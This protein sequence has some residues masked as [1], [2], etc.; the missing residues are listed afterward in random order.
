MSDD[1]DES[2]ELVVRPAAEDTGKGKSLFARAEE[3]LLATNGDFMSDK[4]LN[5]PKRIGLIIAFLVFGVFGVWAAVAPLDGAIHAPG[6]VVLE[7]YRKPI[8]HFEGGIVKSVLVRDGSIVAKGEPIII[9]DNTQSLANLDILQGQ[10]LALLALEARLASERDSLDNIV[11]P[12]ALVAAS[13]PV[14]QIEMNAQ[15]QIF[16][17]RKTYLD[18]ET[19]VLTQ[20]ITQL[21]SRIEGLKAS[22]ASKETLLDSFDAEIKDAT[23]LL[24]EG[25]VEKTRMRE[26]ERTHV[27]TAGDIAEQTATIASTEV[28]V[29]ETKLQILQL[30]NQRQS[31]VVGELS[32]V[33][34]RL[35]DVRERIIALEDIVERTEIRAPEAGVISNLQVHSPATVVPGGA[36]IAELVPQEETLI[37]DARIMPM[38]VDRVHAGQVA[39]ITMTALNARRVPTLSGKVITISA[40]SVLDRGTGATYFLARLAL[41]PESFAKLDGNQLIPGMPAEVFIS[42]GSRTFLQYLMKPITDSMSRSFR[43]D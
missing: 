43:E 15:N 2:Q 31:D 22:K 10:E 11:F 12:P 34:T 36:L 13:N 42:T 5:S 3:R 25:F 6:F 32:E 41:D 16:T 9:L 27:A 30:R 29:G 18:G 35:N 21:Q 4:N 17:A 26:L 33:Q 14:A 39:S 8:Q 28:Q 38:D 24:A 23:A 19:E 20:R 7:S 37:V 40:D 1:I